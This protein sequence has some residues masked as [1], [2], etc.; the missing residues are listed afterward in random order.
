MAIDSVE[1]TDQANLSELLNDK[2][3]ETVTLQLAADANKD[4]KRR[5]QELQAVPRQVT[6]ELMYHRWVAANA[7]LVA[8]LSHGKFG[9]IHLRAMDGPSLDEFVRT[10]YSD[11]W[12]KEA[13]VLDVR[14]NGGGFTH[15]Q[16]LSYLGGREHTFFVTREGT[17]GAVL[18]AND[19][20][21]TKPIILLI[22]HRS[23]SDA[24]IFPSAFRSLGLGKL[25]GTPT[26]GYVIGTGNERLIDG[27][28]FRVPRLGVYTTS[29]I[30]MD[31]AGVAPDVVVDLQPDEV[32]QGKD[33]QIAKAVEMLAKD[34]EAWKRSHAAG[35]A[36][37]AEP[38]KKPDAGQNPGGPPKQ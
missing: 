30:N 33:A 14:Y 3:G 34:V 23:Y 29:G 8:E 17:R 6:A 35:V 4:T 21:W 16:V 15:D 26:G 11:N 38:A 19:R 32:A 2:A 22:N 9:Y 20:R 1:L 25:V 28:T 24:E 36:G 18:R 31:K 13:I 7:K 12:D 10:L 37:A 5:K 27:S